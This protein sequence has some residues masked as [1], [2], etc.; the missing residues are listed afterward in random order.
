MAGS[1][2]FSLLD[3]R[4]RPFL[5]GPG[6]S[7]S[8]RM[9]H[10][11]SGLYPV[12]AAHC[13]PASELSRSREASPAHSARCRK[14]S[15]RRP[16][17]GSP[18]AGRHCRRRSRA[19]TVKHRQPAPGIVR[20]CIGRR[21]PGKCL[22]RAID[23]AKTVSELADHPC[24]RHMGEVVLRVSAADIGV[25]ACEPYFLD[26]PVSFFSMSKR[27]GWKVTRSSSSDNACRAI[28]TLSQS[29]PFLNVIGQ[30][31]TLI[32]RAK[33]L[34]RNAIGFDG[35]EQSDEFD[36]GLVATLRFDFLLHV[37]VGSGNP[38]CD[39]KHRP[40]HREPSGSPIWSAGSPSASS[41]D[42]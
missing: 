16:N 32:A 34:E 13:R 15:S 40:T 20:G 24:Q 4:L 35:V 38:E 21:I 19:V 33:F 30:I 31:E 36:R 27:S 2:S 11:V 22:G 28:S 1:G 3:R 17:D 23:K 12:I 10:L 9:G 42:R 8:A 14:Q 26:A 39:A 29:M 5:C 6:N 7:P 37:G 18:G 25:N 41:C